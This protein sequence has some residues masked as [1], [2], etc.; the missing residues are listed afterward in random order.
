[1][2]YTRKIKRSL[3][4][5]KNVRK[6]R[7]TYRKNV[8]KTRKTYR[9]NVRKTRK[10][11]RKGGVSSRDRR[12]PLKD[13]RPDF[14]NR[15]TRRE[16]FKK[17]GKR[18][19]TQKMLSAREKTHQ[20]I[21]ELLANKE[22]KDFLHDYS[23][24]SSEMSEGDL[25]IDEAFNI[26]FLESQIDD[27]TEAEKDGIEQYKRAKKEFNASKKPLDR[28]KELNKIIE[29]NILNDDAWKQTRRTRN[30]TQNQLESQRLKRANEAQNELKELLEKLDELTSKHDIDKSNLVLAQEVI[31][32][33]KVHLMQKHLEVDN[34]RASAL[35]YRFGQ[36]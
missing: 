1:M 33:F 4:H 35:A 9:K 31:D 2:G 12:M 14:S 28:I 21:K 29:N 16:A 23:D 24:D 10:T 3:K 26:G 25:E 17:E 11:Y 13:R 36:K 30:T 27:L 5:K 22:L 20:Q 32:E 19:R 8:R 15:K 34:A 7:K 18:R 6:T